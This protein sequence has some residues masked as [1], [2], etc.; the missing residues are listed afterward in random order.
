MRIS[1]LASGKRGLIALVD[2]RRLREEAASGGHYADRCAAIV[3]GGCS[4][5][6]SCAGWLSQ[7][8]I[9]GLRLPAWYYGS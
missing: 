6:R 1:R 8:I 9:Q 4:L 5:F 2:E 7:S 3:T